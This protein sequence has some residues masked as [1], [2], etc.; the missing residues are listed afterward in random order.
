MAATRGEGAGGPLTPGRPAD[1]FGVEHVEDGPP[2]EPPCREIPI[3]VPDALEDFEERKRAAERPDPPGSAG[4][5][6]V[7]DGDD[8]G[9]SRS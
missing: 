9:G 1:P 8:D 5:A 2:A 7:D 6:Q 4:D 3:G